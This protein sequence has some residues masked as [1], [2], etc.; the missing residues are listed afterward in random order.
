MLRLSTNYV[1]GSL[2]PIHWATIDA[3]QL[4]LNS[5]NMFGNVVQQRAMCQLARNMTHD[6]FVFVHCDVKHH[7]TYVRN[8]V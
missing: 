1:C 7:N 8:V 2:V 6:L 3:Q 4:T 5:L